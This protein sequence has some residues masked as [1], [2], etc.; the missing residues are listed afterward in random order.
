MNS[1]RAF[2]TVRPA[3]AGITYGVSDGLSNYS[4]LQVTLEKRMSKGL[5]VLA[6]YTWAHAID[7][8]ATE[9]G[10]GAGTPQD[11]RC[12]RCDRGNSNFDL[13]HRMTL[14]STYQLPFFRS[15]GIANTLLGGWQTNTIM[16]LQSGLPF[17]LG[18]AG[19]DVTGGAGGSRPNS[20][21]RDGTLDSG[22]RNLDRWF[23]PAAYGRPDN[24]T[25]GNVAR[26]PLFGPG[27]V[28]FDWSLFKDFALT[29]SF[30]VQ[31][32]TEAFN[33]F[34]HPQFGQPNG[35]IGTGQAGQIRST[36]GNPRQL[37]LALRI[38]F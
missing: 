34:N 17:N 19:G 11:I 8:V 23:D 28:N 5:Q 30:K 25:F 14:S 7:D 32:R 26:N 22:T 12:R 38:Q 15:K 35:N 20:L 36:V 4:A 10:G 37:Q 33:L 1:R 21:G 3:L 18:W 16:T 29:E 31:F 9:F 2:F 24:F 13:R 27:R 6:G